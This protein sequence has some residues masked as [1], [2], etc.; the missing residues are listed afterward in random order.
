[1]KTAMQ[2]LKERLLVDADVFPNRA[3]YV[4]EII[5]DIDGE[6]LEKEKKQIIDAQE[7]GH[8]YYE[9]NGM[10]GEQYYNS[11]FGDSNGAGI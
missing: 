9:E 6:L 3:S 10:E 8:S 7:N 4:Y 5:G 11:T 1:M 2:E